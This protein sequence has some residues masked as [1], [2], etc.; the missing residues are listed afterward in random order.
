MKDLS[1]LEEVDWIIEAVIEQL[2]IKK[3]LFA[4]VEQHWRLGTIVSTNTSGVS[5]E[6]ISRERSV[7]FQRHFL[8]THFFNPP[9]YMK[10]LEMI[11][12]SQTDPEVVNSLS[13]FVERKL[14]KGIVI[15]RD[16][17]NFIAN[18]IGV[19]GFM[20]T[21]E[22]MLK[23]GF[24]TEEVD[25][26]TGPL[27][28]R[29]KSATFRTLD[30]VG[31]DTFVHVA[32]NVRTHISDSLEKKMFTVPSFIEE[33]VKSGQLGDKSGKG[34]YWKKKGEGE[35]KS[36]LLIWLRKNIFLVRK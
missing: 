30:L 5:I 28:G 15:A 2:E 11:P 10:L 23:K 31:L 17:P 9:R 21:L 24:T 32:N 20:V 3:D 25:A 35:E 22:E 36:F 4:K 34:F 18:R 29:P 6:A 13:E 19:Y 33:M 7:P 12:G 14:G 16:T 1:K 8:G 26:M 27:L